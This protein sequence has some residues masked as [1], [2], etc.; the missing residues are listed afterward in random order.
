V[1][2]EPVIE[3]EDAGPPDWQDDPAAAADVAAFLDFAP[4]AETRANG[5]AAA[6]SFA[7]RVT[8]RRVDLV[9]RRREGIP[10]VDYLPASDRMLRRG[11]RH[12]WVAPKKVGKSIGALVHGVDIALAGG[13]LVIF[14]RENGADLYADRFGQITAARG[15]DEKTEAEL[16]GRIDYYEFPRFCDSDQ[17]AIAA[18]CA[19]ADL[20]VFDSQRMY[21]SDLGLEENS[22]DDYAS[23]MASLVEPLFL[24]GVATL[25]LDNAGHQEPKRGR[26]ASAKG[27]LNEI[28]FALE[29]IERFNLDTTGRIR[30]EITDSRF[31]N[32]GRW[33]LEIGGGVFGS[34]RRI[35]DTIDDGTTAFRPTGLMERASI[36]IENC[37]DPPTRRTVTDAIGGKTRYARIAIDC[38]ARERYIRGAKREGLESMKP[39]REATD[40]AAQ[41]PKTSQKGA[42]HDIDSDR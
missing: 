20:V 30:L 34:W 2:T 25:V 26:G 1:T 27:D 6:G 28:L 12:Q 23:F 24:A 14:D 21:L 16:S 7:D 9:Q 11:K 3:F 5:T 22:P 41:P 38:L 10:P 32:S 18:L 4:A 42:P 8:S 31:G 17:Q 40:P 19:G 29:T 33:E 36:F 35:D 37:T 39:Y 13:R 15:L